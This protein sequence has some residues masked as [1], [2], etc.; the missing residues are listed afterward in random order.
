MPPEFAD[1]AEHL[2]NP[3][4]SFNNVDVESFNVESINFTSNR[5]GLIHV[6]IR[7]IRQN[8]DLFLLYLESLSLNFL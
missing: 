6:K 3:C 8:V 7:S 1:L 4:L 5:L 2:N